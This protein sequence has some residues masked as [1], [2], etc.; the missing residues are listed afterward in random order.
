MSDMVR[1]TLLQLDSEAALRGSAR[2]QRLCE[3][4]DV[5]SSK[6]N[7]IMLARSVRKNTHFR[8]ILELQCEHIETQK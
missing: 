8:S 1:G 2:P 4:Q 7:G 3:R 5:F 6:L